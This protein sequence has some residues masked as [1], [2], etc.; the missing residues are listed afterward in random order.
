LDRENAV[1]V[2]EMEAKISD[3]TFDPMICPTPIDPHHLTTARRTLEDA[4]AIEQVTAV[5]KSVSASGAPDEVTT[6]SLPRVR[7]RKT[8]I[9]KVAARKRAL[10]SRWLSWGR[11]HLLGE[12]GESALAAA[13]AETHNLTNASGSTTTVLGVTVGEVDNTAIYVAERDDGLL[14]AIQ[15]MFEVKNKRECYYAGNDEV[16]DFLAKAAVV[17]DARPDQLILPVFV[18]RRRHWTLWDQGEQA[19]FLPTLV[20]NQVVKRDPELNTDDWN[21][22]FR[23]VKDEVFPDLMELTRSVR[24][25]NRHRGIVSTAIPN[26]ALA[27]AKRWGESYS[28]YLPP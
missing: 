26:S 23:E 16:A 27:Y 10:M 12:A 4:G 22:R 18:C 11:R 7:G 2:V 24:T 28:D 20:T 8:E 15:I 5:T 13:L 3:R 9:D 17:Q 19:G 1:T 14:A 25:T 21:T 6:W